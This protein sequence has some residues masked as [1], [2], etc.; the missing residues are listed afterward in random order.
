MLNNKK[1]KKRKKHRRKKSVHCTM[2]QYLM[3]DFRREREYGKG[4]RK[5]KR[6]QRKKKKACCSLKGGT[7]CYISPHVGEQEE[8][9]K[10]VTSKKRKTLTENKRRPLI[11]T[12]TYSDTQV[13]R[14]MPTV[15]DDPRTIMRGKKK[16][17][18]AVNVAEDGR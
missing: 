11:H 16:K 1:K 14:R 18:V 9:K 13:S 12:Y 10:R 6:D 17:Q 3:S 2:E 4:R 5:Y 7:K 15:N 8:K